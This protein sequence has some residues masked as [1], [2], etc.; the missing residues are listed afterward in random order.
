MDTYLTD[1]DILDNPDLLSL[2]EEY[3][4]EIKEFHMENDTL[5]EQLQLISD[6][7]VMKND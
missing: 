7:Q 3:E 2:L 5:V 1:D 6:I 4:E